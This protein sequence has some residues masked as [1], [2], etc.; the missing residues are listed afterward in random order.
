MSP[1]APREILVSL[2]ARLVAIEEKEKEYVD[3]TLNS[4]TT[5][6]STQESAPDSYINK[7][8]ASAPKPVS[9]TATNDNPGLVPVDP[10]GTIS[11]SAAV[12][13]LTDKD[14]LPTPITALV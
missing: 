14:P 6:D 5:L 1:V 12:G 8:F 9:V 4:F 11:I 2:A 13:T 10:A 3:G 7:L